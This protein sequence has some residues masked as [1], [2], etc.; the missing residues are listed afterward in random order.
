MSNCVRDCQPLAKR[1]A[2]KSQGLIVEVCRRSWLQ[3]LNL[4]CAADCLCAW[5]ADY[6]IEG[7]IIPG[8]SSWLN[9][10]GSQAGL[11]TWDLGLVLGWS[12]PTL[13]AQVTVIYIYIYYICVYRY[14]WLRMAATY[15][16]TGPGRHVAWSGSKWQQ[17]QA[18]HAIDLIWS[19]EP[20]VHQ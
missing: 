12:N 17:V 15:W 19:L 18:W 2:G 13:G 1:S 20:P 6:H 9:R 3:I 11:T 5:I 14:C 4:G 16:L 10:I 8:P 7:Y